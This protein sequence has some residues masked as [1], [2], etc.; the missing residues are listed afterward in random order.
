M[1]ATFVKLSI[2]ALYI[3]IFPQRGFRYWVYILGIIN[4]TNDISMTAPT[5]VHGERVLIA[6][7]DELS[8][9]PKDTHSMSTE[10]ECSVSAGAAR[11]LLCKETTLYI[12]N[13]LV[14]PRSTKSPGYIK[15]LTSPR[16]FPRRHISI[17]RADGDEL[18]DSGQPR[19]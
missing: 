1:A 3:A 11:L 17:T 12:Y 8:L 16:V 2:L 9:F 10:G 5:Y 6:E 14:E 7:D 13:L 15:I 19:Q 18:H 4:I